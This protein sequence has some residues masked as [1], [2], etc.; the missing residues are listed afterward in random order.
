MVE[1]LI[2][3]TPVQEESETFQSHIQHSDNTYETDS[4]VTYVL[5]YFLTS[6]NFYLFFYILCLNRIN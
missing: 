3:E 1:T 5:Q 4:Y 6:L 2:Y